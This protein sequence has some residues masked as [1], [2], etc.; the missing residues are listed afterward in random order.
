MFQLKRGKNRFEGE[1][2]AQEEV[3]T[4]SAAMNAS[5]YSSPDGRKLRRR[6]ALGIAACLVI[7]AVIIGVTVHGGRGES[8]NEY[9]TDGTASQNPD[10]IPYQLPKTP[11]SAYELVESDIIE[12]LQ[13]SVAVFKHTKSGMSVL[14]VIPK[15]PNQDATFGINFRTP[16]EQDDGAQYVVE[17]AILAGSVNY[18]IKDPFNQVKRGSLQTYWETWTNRDRTSFVVAS[19][20]LADFGN[21]VKVMID[22][23]F[24]PLFVKSEHKWIYRQEAWRLESPDNKHLAVNGYVPLLLLTL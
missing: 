21:N 13:S 18:P 10:E 5:M 24:H 4:L 19:R 11:T 14:T 9:S 20:N 17:N 6:W 15:D 23:V 8:S 1:A 12:E 7:A 16:P 22:A 2:D 3:T